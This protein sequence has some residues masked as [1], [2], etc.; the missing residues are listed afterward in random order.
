MGSDAQSIATR[1][2]DDVLF[3]QPFVQVHRAQTVSVFDTNDLGL[4]ASL[5]RTDYV[6][7]DL[8]K[9][10]AQVICEFLK[11]IADPFCPN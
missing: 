9:P 5:S 2:S 6:V 11:V 8:A 3:R 4:L 1:C 7:V 10:F